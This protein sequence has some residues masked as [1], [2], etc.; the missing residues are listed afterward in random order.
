MKLVCRLSGMGTRLSDAHLAVITLALVLTRVRILT[1][2]LAASDVGMVHAGYMRYR[3]DLLRAGV[4]L[5]EFKPD[6]GTLSSNKKW[7]GFLSAS[8]HAKFMSADGNLVFV[9]SFNL[10]PRSVALNTEM[11]VLFEN[12]ELDQRMLGAFNEVVV[13]RAYHVQLDAAGDLVWIEYEDGQTLR[14]HEEPR[15]TAW[16]RFVARFLSWVVPESML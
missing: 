4:D 16:Q 2:S 3:K 7:M 14:Y 9:G 1:N 8:L 10:D 11:G 13:S 12:P 15:T 6:P 5:Y